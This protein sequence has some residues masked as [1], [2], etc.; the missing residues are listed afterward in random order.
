MTTHRNTDFDAL[1]SVVAATIIYPES[2]LKI[3]NTFLRPAYGEKQKIIPFRML[4]DA[5]RTWINGHLISISKVSVEGYVDSLAVVV[6]MYL[7]IVNFDAPFGIFHDAW[8]RRC[9]VIGRSRVDGFDVGAIMRST[10]GGGYL[11]KVNPD[12]VEEMIRELIQGNQQASVQIRAFMTSKVP[13]TEP[14]KSPMQDTRLMVK[15]DIGRMRGLII[16]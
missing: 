1:A 12:T 5:E 15:H 6:R 10:G 14:G 13:A 7:E 9:M 8:R 11:K 4:Q 16:S 2:I 3:I